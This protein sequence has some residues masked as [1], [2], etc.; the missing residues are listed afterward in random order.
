MP[1]TYTVGLVGERDKNLY[2]KLIENGAVKVNLLDEN[3]EVI[4]SKVINTFEID[5]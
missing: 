3:E 2:E 4:K 5:M 1:N